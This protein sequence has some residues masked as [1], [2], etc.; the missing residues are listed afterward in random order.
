MISETMQKVAKGK[1][2]GDSKRIERPVSESQESS[3]KEIILGQVIP[4]RD[5]R[6]REEEAGYQVG[7]KIC[8]F[9]V[10]R[11]REELLEALLRPLPQDGQ[12]AA[13]NEEK[14]M[15]RLEIPIILPQAQEVTP[16]TKVNGTGTGE[17]SG[18]SLI[19]EGAKRY[20]EEEDKKPGQIRLWFEDMEDP[21]WF[22]IVISSLPAEEWFSQEPKEKEKTGPG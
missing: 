21:A 19:K 2:T 4:L 17:R 5:K 8:R 14:W 18:F 16:E 15:L 11:I 22:Q 7:K 6:A 20:I 3:L 12:E 1:G 13:E 10:S 9:D